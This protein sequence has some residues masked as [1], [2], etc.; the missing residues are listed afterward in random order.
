MNAHWLAA[1]AI[2]VILP[3]CLLGFSQ[4]SEGGRA[5]RRPHSTI[6]T[7]QCCTVAPPVM[8]WVASI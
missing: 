6:K 8:F 4:G 7:A 1:L 3:L 5:L 2:A